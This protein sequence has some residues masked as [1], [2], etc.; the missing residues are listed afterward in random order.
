[1]ANLYNAGVNSTIYHYFKTEHGIPLAQYILGVEIL[2]LQ[3][4]WRRKL[5]AETCRH[6]IIN[7]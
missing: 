5:Q 4:W 6:V 3:A 7:L 2:C 1:M